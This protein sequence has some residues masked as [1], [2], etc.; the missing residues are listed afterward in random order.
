[1][2]EKFSKKKNWT[3]SGSTKGFRERKRERER[4]RKKKEKKFGI[5]P[6]KEIAVSRFAKM[7]RC[8]ACS[9]G[10]V[11]DS[12]NIKLSESE[13]FVPFTFVNPQ[14]F[15]CKF[16]ERK[17]KKKRKNKKKRERENRNIFLF[18]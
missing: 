15:E 16:D 9:P 17:I 5:V 13:N 3:T 11:P 6:T 1:M 18:E 8:G 2:V 10:L 4:E 12:V 14:R 7:P